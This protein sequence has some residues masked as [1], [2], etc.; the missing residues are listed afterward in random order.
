[1]VDMLDVFTNLLTSFPDGPVMYSIEILLAIVKLLACSSER[2]LPG[3]R[4]MGTKDYVQQVLNRGAQPSPAQYAA[5]AAN[6]SPDPASDTS[7]GSPH[8]RASARA[9]FPAPISPTC[10]TMK[11]IAGA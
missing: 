6:Y 7:T 8:P 3:L 11:S 5:A 10:M 4:A 1:M 2:G 9:M